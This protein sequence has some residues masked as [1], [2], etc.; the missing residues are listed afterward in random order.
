MIYKYER[1]FNMSKNSKGEVKKKIIAIMALFVVFLMVLSV[2][3]PIFYS[4]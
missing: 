3:A 1:R 2:A 4:F